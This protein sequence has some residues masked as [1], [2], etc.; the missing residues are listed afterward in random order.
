MEKHTKRISKF[1]LALS[2]GF[3]LAG[4]DPITAVPTNYNKPIISNI[5]ENQPLELKDNLLGKIYDAVAQDRNTKIVSDLLE[6]VAKQQLGSYEEIFSD[7]SKTDFLNSHSNIFGEAAD[8]NR[9]ERFSTFVSDLQER[10]DEF[11]YNE[12][13]GESYKDDLGRF[14]E[15]KF[16]K[17]RIFELYDVKTIDKDTKT[18]LENNVFFIT[19]SK[20][21]DGKKT[22]YNTYLFGDYTDYIEKK[23]FPQ[24]LKDKLVEQYIYDENP[25][26]LGLAYA[27]QVNMIKVP[28]TS[29]ADMMPIIENFC[30]TFIEGANKSAYDLEILTLAVKGFT[31][32]GDFV[33]TGV[34]PLSTTGTV[35]DIGFN[36]YTLLNAS[37]TEMVEV[38]AAD[39]SHYTCDNVVLIPAGNY[40][41]C[42]K[43]GA[44]ID[45]YNK[46]IQAEKDGRF[47]KA[48]DKA[49]LDKFTGDNKSKEF[50]LRKKII[51]LAKEDYTTDG[52]FVKN[53]GLSDLPSALRDRLFNINVAN[54][55]DDGSLKYEKD[56]I[57]EKQTV[58][59]V[60]YYPIGDYETDKSGAALKRLPYLRN[61]NGKKFVIPAKSQSFD[62][63]HF[64]YAYHDGESKA[65]YFVEVVEA[66]S[67]PKLKE[68]QEG[69]YAKLFPDDTFK[70]ERISRQVA[71]VLS[72]KDTFIKDAYTKYLKDY[73][74]TFYETSLYEHFK[75]EYP[76]LFEDED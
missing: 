15:D 49:E 19:P 27:R 45:S 13:S 5:D 2:A 7:G 48:N 40:F 10:I 9:D 46:A 65:Y 32:V 17:N 14:S 54:T 57:S 76:D 29:Q 18:K 34:Q 59:G 38:K 72:T 44:I 8:T 61:I 37:A 4:C 51:D 39:I 75:S 42:T 67:K 55:L 25:S 36:A 74:F 47:A 21:K 53:G 16:F 11:F 43:I 33:T 26:S 41:K 28:Y 6:Y 64:N 66:P 3:I 69:S 50:N 70:T 58:E 68:S 71:K 24:I 52:W 62:A 20:L 35:K 22:H 31:S 63:N 56:G 60:T 30:K 1:V 73:T 23:I 12:I